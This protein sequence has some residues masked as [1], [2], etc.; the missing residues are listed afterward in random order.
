MKWLVAVLIIFL[1]A[2]VIF[3]T[4][5]YFFRLADP[6]QGPLK[7]VARPAPPAPLVNYTLVI[8]AGD[9]KEAFYKLGYAHAYYR[10]FQMD[11]MRRVAEGKLSELL[12]EAAFDTDVYFRT[13]GLYISAERTWEYIKR[14]YPQ[15][16]ELI[17]EYARGVNDFLASR[18]PIVEYLILGK[19]PEP[20]SPVDTLAIAKLVAWSLSG[21]EDDIELKALVEALGPQFLE[22]ALAREGN[23]PILPRKV[24]FT[25]P[26]GMGSNN[27]IIS[28]NFTAT[29]MPIL[30]NDPHLSLSAPPIWIFQRVEMP[31]YTVM[32]VAF[33]G[34]PVVVIGTNGYV[35]WG[36]TNTGVDVIDYYFYVWNGTRYYYNGTWLDA[37]RRVEKIKI[38]DLNNRCAERSLEVLETVHGPVIEYKGQKYS[39]KW[40]G[41]N[42]TLEALALYYMNKARNL[43]EFLNGLK[44][45]V[46]PS[47]NTVYADRYGVVAY[48]AN[49][50]FPIREGG[51]LP[52]N[53]SKGEGEW[54]GFVWLPSVLYYVNPPYLA[55]ANNKI[56]D[57]NIYLQ[58]SWADRYRHDRIMELI[59]QKAARGKISVKDVMD[60]QRDVVD[61]SCRDVRTLLD[62]YG[63]EKG[64]ELLNELN[65]WDCSMSAESITAARYAVLLYNL[66]KLAWGKFNISITF[67]PFEITLVAIKRGLIDRSIVEKAAEEALKINTPWGNLHKYSISH[68]LGG[69]FPG[70]NYKKVEAPGDW[71]TVNVAPGFDVSHGP[72]VRFIAA[73][74]DGVYMMLPGG[75]DGDP[76]SPLYDAMYMPWVRGEYVKVG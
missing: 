24:T 3:L 25:S 1:V 49:G 62:L 29:G 73:F 71:F 59:A 44:Y 34:A 54:R 45:F 56:A 28:P 12:G 50:Y 47:Q 22:I 58:W 67:V 2:F 57:A 19:S 42:V 69:V 52:F 61:I 26:L 6:F 76:L 53:G 74:G 63:G 33:P 65:K 46:T 35:A 20:W 13:R 66:Q 17:E 41:N 75:P 68:V 48:F 31:N 60:I 39:M 55:T 36:F 70:L 23:T 9:E 5:P 27:W 72:S 10:F 18:Q 32:G 21:G 38:C 51:Y 7:A 4:P 11:V 15:Y 37:N 43:T 30:A 64:R 40:L 16:A 14:N 8:K